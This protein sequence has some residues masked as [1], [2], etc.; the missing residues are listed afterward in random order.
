ML[1]YVADFAGTHCAYP[2]RDGHPELTWVT[3]YIPRWF[4]SLLKVT[5]QN[6][7]W[8][9]CWLTLLVQPTEPKHCRYTECC[10]WSIEH[11]CCTGFG[12]RGAVEQHHGGGGVHRA[13]A[14]KAC[15]SSW[16]RRSEWV[17]G[18]D[19]WPHELAALRHPWKTSLWEGGCCYISRHCSHHQ[20]PS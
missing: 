2:R 16:L 4:T 9:K 14:A 20:L 11:I 6:A 18:Q 8:A 5:H 10:D 12:I 17:H 3:G 13:C 1:F 7:N 19:G 15:S